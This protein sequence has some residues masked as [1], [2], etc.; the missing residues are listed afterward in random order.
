MHVVV[1]GHVQ[2]QPSQCLGTPAAQSG[3]LHVC[4]CLGSGCWPPAVHVR[5]SQLPYYS[6][7]IMTNRC[8]PESSGFAVGH[9][10]SNAPDLF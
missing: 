8:Q 10:M 5:R 2:E 4:V 1:R 7:E 9:T 6:T 3:C